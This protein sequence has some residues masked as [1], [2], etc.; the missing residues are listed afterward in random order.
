MYV[1]T[2]LQIAIRDA[3]CLRVLLA[4]APFDVPRQVLTGFREKVDSLAVHGQFR[5]RVPPDE[6]ATDNVQMTGCIL[7][8]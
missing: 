5:A 4:M 6:R 7:A 1:C 2:Y 8:L 3:S